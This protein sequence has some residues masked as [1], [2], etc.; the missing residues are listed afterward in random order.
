MAAMHLVLSRHSRLELRFIVVKDLVR[1][2]V[3]LSILSW[4]TANAAFA[5]SGEEPKYRTLTEELPTS[6]VYDGG[7][8][9]YVGGGVAV[10][11]CNGDAL[12]DVFAAGGSNSSTLLINE[13]PAP[14]A[15]LSFGMAPD[16][17]SKIVNVIGAY[18]IDINGDALLDLFVLRVGANRVLRGLGDCRFEDATDAWSIDSG[19]G[20]STAFSAVWER[21]YDWPTL[22]VGNYVDRDDPEGPFG[23]C[24]SHQL[25][26]PSHSA[27]THT[28]QTT[29]RTAKR[30]TDTSGYAAAEIIAPGYCALS[31]LFTDWSGTGR[32]DLWISNDRHYYVNDGHEQLFRL[33]PVL[34]EFTDNDGW[35]NHKLWGMGIASRDITG[36]NLPEIAITS[37]ADQK[38]FTLDDPHRP[39]FKSLSLARNMTAHIP[40]V[41]DEGRPSTGWHVQFGDVNNDGRDDVFIAKGNVNQMPSAAMADPDNLLVQQSDGLFAEKGDT[42]GVASMERGRGAALVDFD[43]DGRLDLLVLQRRAPMALY[44]NVTRSNNHWL[45]VELRQPTGNRFAIGAKIELETDSRHV[46]REIQLGGGHAGGQQVAAHFGLGAERRA[47]IRA[48]WPDGT[49]S[50]WYDIKANRRY[51]IDKGDKPDDSSLHCVAGCIEN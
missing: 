42:A 17:V 49:D 20:W 27:T 40:Y 28:T 51:R 44:Q 32:Q 34:S 41:G 21:G 26:R 31:M 38:L 10:F 13:T 25:L 11:D 24:D 50:S 12:P 47:R 23:T 29:E 4:C 39:A 15:A 46:K 3:R 6:H 43:L 14:G 8:E 16:Q 5:V 2:T 18:P 9:F 48:H 35:I 19:I 45:S 36:D 37:M 7:W 33:E 1:R 30:T 22:A